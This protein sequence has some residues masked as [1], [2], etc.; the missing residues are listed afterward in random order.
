VA[1]VLVDETQDVTHF[2]SSDEHEMIHVTVIVR[3]VHEV[4]LMTSVSGR[5]GRGLMYPFVARLPCLAPSVPVSEEWI[6]SVP[7]RS[8]EFH[9]SPS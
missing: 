5:S 4:E 2:V 1:L 8:L 7:S 9:L 3:I 6:I